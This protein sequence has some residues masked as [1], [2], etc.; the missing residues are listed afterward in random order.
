MPVTDTDGCD[1]SMSEIPGVIGPHA[2]SAALEIATTSSDF[3]EFMGF[4]PLI[5][6]RHRQKCR[7]V[8]N[9]FTKEGIPCLFPQAVLYSAGNPTGLLA[10]KLDAARLGN[11]K[12]EK[13]AKSDLTYCF[14][15][16]YL[17]MAEWTK[18]EFS[19]QLAVIAQK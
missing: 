17:K 3:V 16:K 14:H 2:K 5:V 6:D 11:R 4:P 15:C 18:S 7:A 19:C 1:R 10:N 9:S 12:R 8:S 13:Q